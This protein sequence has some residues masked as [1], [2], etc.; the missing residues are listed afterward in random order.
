MTISELSGLTT[1]I[2]TVPIIDYGPNLTGV[3]PSRFRQSEQGL[4]QFKI[5]SYRLHIL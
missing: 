2:N 5:R 4:R 3:H 1:L